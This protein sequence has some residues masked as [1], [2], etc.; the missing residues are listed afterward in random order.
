SGP[1]GLLSPAG[2]ESRLLPRRAPLAASMDDIYS[3]L[4]HAPL[5]SSPG[6]RFRSTVTTEDIGQ[7]ILWALDFRSLKHVITHAML[8]PWDASPSIPGMYEQLLGPVSDRIAALLE[9]IRSI[10]DFT[11]ELLERI[12]AAAPHRHVEWVGSLRDLTH[13]D[14]AM[15]REL[16][17]RYLLETG[18]LACTDVF[19]DTPDTV[20]AV[21]PEENERFL[22]FLRGCPAAGDG[23]AAG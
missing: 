10:A 8:L 6:I 2:A 12:S 7:P 21:A 14:C 11:P 20:A 19:A 16:R 3:S 1:E 22:Q 13:G 4:D 17:Y 9:P 15:A 23:R 18:S 5:Y